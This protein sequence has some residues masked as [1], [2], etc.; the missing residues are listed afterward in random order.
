MTLLAIRVNRVSGDPFTEDGDIKDDGWE[1][2]D[3]EESIT[4]CDAND[5]WDVENAIADVKDT[6]KSW[7]KYHA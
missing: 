7:F 6:L 5:I 2:E 1:I 3:G 4:F